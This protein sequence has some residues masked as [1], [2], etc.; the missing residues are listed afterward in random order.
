MAQAVPSKPAAPAFLVTGTYAG[1]KAPL[2][3]GAVALVNNQVVSFTAPTSTPAQSSAPT[4][5]N[6]QGLVGDMTNGIAVY[7]NNGTATVACLNSVGFAGGNWYNLPALPAN[8]RIQAMCGDL[9]NGLVVSDGTN[10]YSMLFS[11]ATLEWT[12]LSAPP[13]GTISGIAGDPTNGILL[14][15]GANG[16]P[17]SLYYAAGGCSCAWT[18][19]TAASTSLPVARI[20]VSLVSGNANGFVIYG[21]N[22][23][24][25][26]T[27][28]FTA[29][30]ATAAATAVAT[31]ARMPSPPF[32]I[33]ALTGD[34]VNGCTV[35]AGSS[36][37]I[38]NTDKTF[39]N[40]T[41][42]NAAAPAAAP[43]PAPV[44]APAPDGSAM[45][46]AA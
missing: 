37:L 20:K 5:Q 42:L 2:V 32:T 46:Q 12:L 40:W 8:T 29:G 6:P 33:T 22:Q 21:E 23:I 11:G 31:P 35:M 38:A 25:T 34:P 3:N 9:Q 7:S 14:V 16:G 44:P 15:I 28:K 19:L 4:L 27:V 43:V 13:A 45:Q 41:V 10:L 18:P 30:T 26:Y 39:A 36:G 24:Y 1:L 17:S